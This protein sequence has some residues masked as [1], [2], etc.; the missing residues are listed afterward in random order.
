MQIN[1]HLFFS[2]FLN[3]LNKKSEKSYMISLLLNKLLLW[4]YTFSLFPEHYETTPKVVAIKSEPIE[5]SR[6]RKSDGG[7]SQATKICLK[8][9]IDK[10]SK[11]L[12]SIII[13][14]TYGI[15]LF[16]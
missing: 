16:L 8:F 11:Q 14:F 6:K 15:I 1:Q 10:S 5:Y 2:N 12:G 3:E 7:N 13:S 9:Q 4:Y